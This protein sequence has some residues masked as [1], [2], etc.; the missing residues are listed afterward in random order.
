VNNVSANVVAEK[1]NGSLSEARL[2]DKV[3]TMCWYAIYVTFG[4]IGLA[5]FHQ[6]DVQSNFQSMTGDHGDNRFIAYTLE[7]TFQAFRGQAAILSPQMFYPVAGTLGYSDALFGI[8]PIYWG[9]RTLDLGVL[10]STQWTIIIGNFLTYLLTLGLFRFGLKIGRLGSLFGALLFAYNSAKFN[11]L[12]HLQLQPL[13][14]ITGISW[15]LAICFQKYDRLSS[16][17]SFLLMTAIGL[18]FDLQLYTSVYVGWYFAFQCLLVLILGLGWRQV[19]L[20]SWAFIK[21]HSKS[22]FGAIVVSGV[23]LVPFLK[24]YLPVLRQSGWRNYSEV[25]GM[26][27]QWLSFIYMGHLNYMWGWLPSVFPRIWDLPQH[28]EHRIGLGAVITILTP[29]LIIAAILVYRRAA[30][31]QAMPKWVSGLIGR[32]DRVYLVTMSTFIL[33]VGIFYLL[34]TRI[35]GPDSAWWLV[36]HTVPGARSIRAVARFVLVTALPLSGVLA[37]ILENQLTR[38]SKLRSIPARFLSGLA[39]VSISGFTLAEQAGSTVGFSV[40]GESDRITHFSQTLAPNCQAFYVTVDGSVHYPVWELQLDAMLVSQLAGVPTL[41]GYSGQSPKDWDLWEI[42][43]PA[44][45]TRVQSWVQRNGLG[46][47]ICHVIIDR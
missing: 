24:I 41:N 32:N 36:F 12:N 28:W 3:V 19:R 22:I 38:A 6:I 40:G 34:A 46:G 16:K 7:H 20:D 5:Y 2:H 37:A 13:F 26:M 9:L 25:L 45:E 31:V 11:Q 14:I 35:K 29:V 27:P 18:A 30:K 17:Q 43:D 8:A 10:A 39:L 1:F 33:A 47:D 23:A 15:L 21:L 42:R 4:L 44:Y